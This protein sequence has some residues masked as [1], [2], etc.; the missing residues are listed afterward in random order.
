[1]R[2]GLGCRAGHRGQAAAPLR[3][4]KHLER[5]GR[6]AWVVAVSSLLGHRKINATDGHLE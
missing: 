6:A 1:M 3:E 4:E 5:R 2:G